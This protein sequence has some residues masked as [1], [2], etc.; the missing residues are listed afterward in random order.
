MTYRKADVLIVIM[1]TNPFPNIVSAAT[2][3]RTDG[4]IFCICSKDT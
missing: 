4:Y 1:G 2:R 3:V